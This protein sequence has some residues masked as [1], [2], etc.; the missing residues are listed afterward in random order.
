MC[1]HA[2]LRSASSSAARR[3]L[4]F[5]FSASSACCRRCKAHKACTKSLLAKTG[6][7]K[8]L[9]R[10]NAVHWTIGELCS[11]QRVHHCTAGTWSSSAVGAM[12]WLLITASFIVQNSHQMR[13]K[14]L[15]WVLSDNLSFSNPPLRLFGSPSLFF[16]LGFLFLSLEIVMKHHTR[17]WCLVRYSR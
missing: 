10:R 2:T 13:L 16:T 5:S 6:K 11:R 9:I 1:M 14:S 15:Q 8:K 17:Y 4:S 3:C 7:H 12:R